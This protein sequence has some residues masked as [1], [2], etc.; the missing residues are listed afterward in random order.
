MLT[1]TPSRRISTASIPAP[2]VQ[3]N[4]TVPPLYEQDR[5]EIGSGGLVAVQ[6]VSELELPPETPVTP[7]SKMPVPEESAWE[8]AVPDNKAIWTPSRVTRIWL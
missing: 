7:Y 6:S 5:P 4:V 3:N 2:S 1:S 8:V